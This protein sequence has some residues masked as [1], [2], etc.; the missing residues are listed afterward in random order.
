MNAETAWKLFCATGV[1]A[2]YLLYRYL[3]NRV[4][5]EVSA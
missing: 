3:T 2:H 1:P 4:E 5:E